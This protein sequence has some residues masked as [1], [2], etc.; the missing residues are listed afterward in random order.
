MYIIWVILELN[1]MD[2]LKV[3]NTDNASNPR[4]TVRSHIAVWQHVSMC[5]VSPN[6]KLLFL[7]ILIKINSK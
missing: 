4:H 5:H 1:K 6:L 2:L 7:M 3:L